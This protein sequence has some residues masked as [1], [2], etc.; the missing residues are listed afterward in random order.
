[1]AGKEKEFEYSV[2]SDLGVIEEGTNGYNTEAKIISWNGGTPKLDIRKWNDETGKM[3]KGI[4]ISL[5]SVET[6]IDILKNVDESYDTV[7][8]DDIEM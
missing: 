8:N 7:P 4:S 2:L 5:D 6:L 1:M 3:G